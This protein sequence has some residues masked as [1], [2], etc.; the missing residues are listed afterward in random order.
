MSKQ[1]T[2]YVTIG[3]TLVALGRAH[4]RPDLRSM[5]ECGGLS[6]YEIHPIGDLESS[7]ALVAWPDLHTELARVKA[8]RDRAV[9]IIKEH[10]DGCAAA[11]NARR[12]CEDYR[13]YGRDCPD[14]PKEW[15]VD[16]DPQSEWS[17]LLAELEAEK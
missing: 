11:C 8:Q 10:N 6:G 13:V 4:N 7:T 17:K 5:L 15:M 3:E 12:N 14:C 16:L 9:A 1:R 2:W